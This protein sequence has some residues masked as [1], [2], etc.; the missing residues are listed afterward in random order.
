MDDSIKQEFN[1]KLDF[2]KSIMSIASIRFSIVNAFDTDD[3]CKSEGTGFVVDAENG[4]ILTNR[5]IIG[6][7]PFVGEAILYDHEEIDVYPVY[8]DPVHDFGFLRFN[9]KDVKYLKL[10]SIPLRPDLAKVGLDIRVVGNDAG[11]KLSILSG[12]ISR[13]NRNSPEYGELTYNDFN[14]FY[15]QAASNSS[16]G[17]SGSP[18]LDLNGNAV[19][20]QAGGRSEAATNFFLPLDRVKRALEYIQRGETVP[21]GSIMTQFLHRPFDE[22]HRLGLSDA[23]EAKLRD[24][25]PNEIGMLTVELVVPEGPTYNKL[26]NGDLLLSVNGTMLTHF[27]H[28]DGILDD[29]VNN[30][31]NLKIERGGVEMEFDILVKDLHAITPNRYLS[32]CGSTFNDLSYQLARSFCIPCKG[33]YISNPAGPFKLHGPGFGTIVTSVDDQ[34]TPDL[35]TFIE[36]VSKIPD[37]KRV[38]VVFY[39]I[40][41]VHSTYWSIVCI[42]RHWCDFKLAVRN[43]TNGKWEFTKLK[44]PIPSIPLVRKTVTFPDINQDSKSARI[45]KNSF[46]KVTYQLAGKVEGF[47]RSRCK[48]GGWVLDAEKGIVVI[49]RN[50]V[51][52]DL[53]DISLTFAESFTI[54]AKVLF[55]HPFHNFTLLQYDPE[56]LGDTKVHTPVISDVPLTPGDKVEFLGVNQNFRLISTHTTISDVGFVTIPEDSIP[57]YRAINLNSINVDSPTVLSCH[58][59]LL[60]DSEGRLQ[61]LWLSFLGDR[62]SDGYHNEYYFGIDISILLPALNPLRKGITPELNYLNIEFGVVDLVQARHKGLT[63]DWIEKYE[64]ADPLRRQIFQVRRSEFSAEKPLLKELDLILTVDNKI[65]TKVSDFDT[66]FYKKELEITVLRGKDILNLKVPTKPIHGDGIGRIVS[67]AGA[68]LHEPHKEVLLQTKR[69][70]SKVYVADRHRGSPAYMYG[71]NHTNWITAVNDIPTPDLDAFLNVVKSLSDNTYARVRIVTFNNSPDVLSIKV[72][73]HYWPMTEL[74]KDSTEATGWKKIKH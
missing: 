45:L 70:P 14:T 51:P 52:Y 16:G 55:L 67:W 6:C 29:N 25:F 72:N 41:D 1:W 31:I 5:H 61:G 44:E 20:L 10:K 27:A 64:K 33:V 3:P 68:L 38:Q 49:T 32:Y 2:E 36:V 56:L 37:R 30:K 69:L 4:I 71:L 59:G 35:D 43:D 18:V 34:E 24:L 65:P 60:S 50:C 22:A 42:D 19:A 7:G 66:Q 47:P 48:G 8:R 11:E 21:R 28:L 40:K 62:K 58:S 57:C 9:P 12:S 17:S 46:V 15:I 53:G 63:D 73:H 23:N 54:P 39:F 74:Y 13:L 26:E